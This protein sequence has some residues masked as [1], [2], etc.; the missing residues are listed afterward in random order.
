MRDFVRRPPAQKR[1]GDITAAIAEALSL[2]QDS[3]KEHNIQVRQVTETELPSVAFDPKQI[4]QVLIN[5]FKNAQEAMPGG[6]E[7]T[8]ASRVRGLHLEVS[9]SDTG[10]GMPPEVI[11]SIFQPYFTTKEM[12]TGLGLAICQS[13]MQEHGGCILADSAP[14]RG[15]TF[16]IQLPLEEAAPGA[17]ED[18]SP[19]RGA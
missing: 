10:R 9:I 4:Q 3:L 1:Q 12:G 13:I 14:G 19:G 5:L 2:F 17:R 7:L 18:L 8:I 15:S 11:S 16:T 6:G